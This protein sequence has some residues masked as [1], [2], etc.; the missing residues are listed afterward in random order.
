MEEF[1][2]VRPLL[3]IGKRVGQQLAGIGA[4]DDDPSI[5]LLAKKMQDLFG[6]SATNPSN[7]P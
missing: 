2:R 5:D 1:V 3:D 4:T 6:V 7:T